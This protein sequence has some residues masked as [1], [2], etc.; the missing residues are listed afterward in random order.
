MMDHDARDWF[1][2]VLTLEEFYRRYGVWPTALYVP[3]HTMAGILE[4]CI[5]PRGLARLME[6]EPVITS[7]HHVRTYRA[8]GADGQSHEYGQPFEAVASEASAVKWL[9]GAEAFYGP[10]PLL[11]PAPGRR[12]FL[13]TWRI[14]TWEAVLGELGHQPLR[15][16]AGGGLGVVR[17]GDVVWIVTAEPV[18]AFEPASSEE[19][20]ARGAGVALRLVGRVEAAVVGDVDTAAAALG[21]A[22]RDLWPSPHHV[23]GDAAGAWPLVGQSCESG[24]FLRQLRT[25]AGE[26]FE[27]TAEALR[28]SERRPMAVGG[29][30]PAVF[31]GTPELTAAP[32]PVVELAAGQEALLADWWHAALE[33]DVQNLG[34]E[35]FID[36]NAVE[37]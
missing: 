28:E 21:L 10:D 14:S 23:V 6:G 1:R 20:P 26:G 34:Q 4:D 31:D 17:P 19:G 2:A 16:T 35:W 7:D 36:A 25:A 29:S 33:A 12:H 37:G 32:P 18:E 27:L 3:V 11:E 13:Q 22:A 24:W 8:V 30:F 15:H 5:G 9:G